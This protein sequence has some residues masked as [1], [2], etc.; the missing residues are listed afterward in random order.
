MSLADRC[1]YIV[2][3]QMENQREQLH[4]YASE[5][6]MMDYY[7][8]TQLWNHSPIRQLSFKHL[9]PHVK[10]MATGLKTG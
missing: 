3:K 6:D 1:S 5:V 4:V 7:S 2:I 9:M 10:A 8:S